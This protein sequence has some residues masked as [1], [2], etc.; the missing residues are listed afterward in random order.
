MKLSRRNML[1]G[2]A[3]ATLAACAT[4]A[5][6]TSSQGSLLVDLDRDP[7]AVI[8]LWPDGAPGGEAV[9]LNQHYVHRDNAFGLKD[10][11]VHEVTDP[12][13]TLFRAARPNGKS[14]I[15]IPGGGYKWVVVE[16]E[17]H[18]GARYFNRFGY[19]VYVMSYR[20][21]HQGWAAGPDT[22]LQDAQ[23]PCVWCGR[24]RL[25][26]ASIPGLS[27]SWASRQAAISP[28]RSVSASM[29]THMRRWTPPMSCQPAPIR[30]Y[31]SIRSR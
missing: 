31:W 2:A 10:R 3:G 4:P 9:S 16:K 19:D 13:L 27:W 20:L 30:A 25:S 12:T 17:G 28:G 7:D 29:P 22:P 18:E 11:A 21:P 23:R 26:T 5:P 1:T 6:S 8:P 14:I 24:A 15:I